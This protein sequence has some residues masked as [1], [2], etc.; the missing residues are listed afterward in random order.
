MISKTGYFRIF[1]P[2][3][4]R[5][6]IYEVVDLEGYIPLKK[7]LCN[8]NRA[9]VNTI[10]E[11]EIILTEGEVIQRIINI[12]LGIPNNEILCGGCMENILLNLQSNIQLFNNYSLEN[13]SLNTFNFNSALAICRRPEYYE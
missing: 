7:P 10:Q 2:C 1:N 11:G 5:Y 6:H 4:H 12:T 9:S 13:F 8:S 3:S